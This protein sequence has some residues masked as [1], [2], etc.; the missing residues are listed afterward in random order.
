M[1]VVVAAP[2]TSRSRAMQ[3]TSPISL[4]PSAHRP[5][6]TWASS[7]PRRPQRHKK[8]R[9]GVIP[10][11]VAPFA[12]GGPGAQVQPPHHR[13]RCFLYR[14]LRPPAEGSPDRRRTRPGRGACVDGRRSSGRLPI[15]IYP[16][17]CRGPP[18][19]PNPR[20]CPL[21]AA[22]HTEW[23][24]AFAVSMRQRDVSRPNDSGR[25]A[26][27]SYTHIGNFGYR[28]TEG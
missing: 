6:V 24:R 20:L 3:R 16:Y 5:M 13:V 26:H 25:L 12:L 23:G 15:S 2:G 21:I 22:L 1:V 10:R 18:L 4:S 8:N 11:P 7:R 17:P 28:P 19:P 27:L 9:P 14:T